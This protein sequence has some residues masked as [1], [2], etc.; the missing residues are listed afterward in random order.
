MKLIGNLR[1]QVEKAN[2]REEAMKIIEKA[3]MELTSEEL[4]IV[5]GGKGLSVPYQT[6]R[7][8]DMKPYYGERASHA[9]NPNLEGY[10]DC[11]GPTMGNY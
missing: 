11:A 7:N 8:L 3:G 2:N 5:T 1:D 10:F 6:Q 4:D 9:D